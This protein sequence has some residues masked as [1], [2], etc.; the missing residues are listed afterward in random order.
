VKEPGL[1]DYRSYDTA[2]AFV[3]DLSP[4]AKLWTDTGGVWDQNEAGGRR[5]WI[6]RGQ[7]RSQWDLSPKAMRPRE[8]VYYGIGS[9][10]IQSPKS[11]ADQLQCEREEVLRF[12][13]R[14]IRAGM[15][16]PEDS[17]WFRNGSLPGKVFAPEVGKEL[18]GGVDFP[19]ALHRSLFALAQHHGVPTRLLDWTESPLVAAYF[20]CRDAAEVETKRRRRHSLATLRAKR[21]DSELP[22]SLESKDRLVVC[23]LRQ[24]AFAQLEG[25][26]QRSKLEPT[27]QVVEAP[28]DCN[29]NL[30]A[31]RGLFTLVR[32]HT[33]RQQ[34]DF[35]LPSIDEVIVA[36]KRSSSSNG[37][38]NAPWLRKMTLP[39]AEAPRL[40]RLL[41]QFNVNAGTMFPSYD[42]VVQSIREREFF[43]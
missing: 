22:R 15:P 36:Y 2:D 35:Q 13:R 3:Q 1:I 42:G 32:Y 31:Q 16:L 19:F 33:L 18:V 14:C 30:R 12:V 17:Q 24:S 34:D 37:W 41:D 4:A 40:L 10:G 27:L 29:P 25:A 9:K 11:L 21:T 6:F 5:N 8:L 20:A 39:Q 28:F 7:R 26:W 43:G 38:Q 23:A